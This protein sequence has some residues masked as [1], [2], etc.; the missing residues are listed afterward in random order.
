MPGSCWTWLAMPQ[1]VPGGNHRPERPSCLGDSCRLWALVHEN[2]SRWLL[3]PA[4]S[5]DAAGLLPI[6]DTPLHVGGPSASLTHRRALGEG[7][8]V[9]YQATSVGRVFRVG[10]NSIQCDSSFPLNLIQVGTL[11]SFWWITA[12]QM[13]PF[14]SFC[15]CRGVFSFRLQDFFFLFFFFFFFFFPKI[16]HLNSVSPLD[17]DLTRVDS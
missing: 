13:L 3:C 11:V 1:G 14:D 9:R 4:P 15:F 2:L 5:W 16:T 6:T 12:A 8:R 17:C 10:L 7:I